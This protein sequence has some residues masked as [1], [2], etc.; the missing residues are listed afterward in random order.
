[1]LELLEQQ[2]AAFF[3]ELPVP[4]AIRQDRLRRAVS[5]IEENSGALCAAL[6]RDRAQ[7]DQESAM[8]IEV[9]PA[10]AALRAALRDAAAWTRPV[11][12][13]RLWSRLRHGDDTEYQPA[14]V[15][16][17][18]APAAD[19]LR[20]T[21]HLLADALAAGNR[22]LV[23]F[24]PATPHLG[25][26]FAQLASRYFDSLELYIL[27]GKTEDAGA[28]AT[29]PFDLLV[30][31]GPADAINLTATRHEPSGKSPAIIG[32]SADLAKVA[33]AVIAHKFGKADRLPPDYLLVPAE[34]MEA[35]ASW[36]W[37][38]AMHL[39]PRRADPGPP[40][41]DAGLAHLERLIEDA[42]A[43]GG[44]I[45]VAGPSDTRRTPLHIVRHTTEDMEVMREGGGASILPLLGYG[46][47][48]DAIGAI[49]RL[50]VPAA[51]H[52][53][54][55]DDAERRHVLA[56]TISSVIALDGRS[57]AAAKDNARP[58]DSAPK[59]DPARGGAGFR[60]F[61]RARRIFR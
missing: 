2:R 30:T 58:V 38:A 28:F 49:H 31:A 43:R 51:I 34:E 14:G 60:G 1:M 61:S 35:M 32:R 7:P 33:D 44:E 41:S 57:L 17:I 52:H 40:P 25:R 54:G 36:L 22:V 12:G 20:K 56:R 11:R 50:G 24:D 45:L 53:F 23:Q 8:R 13:H 6:C 21:V 5:M 26:V 9:A 3:S 10:L 37:R 48:D 15:V 19:P 39:L 29:L 55:R 27:D 46:S 18:A 47:I 42:R 4:P 16:G 59:P